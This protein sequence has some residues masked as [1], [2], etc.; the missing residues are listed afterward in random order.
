[1][2]FVEVSLDD[3]AIANRL[4]HQVLGR[5]L[6]ELSPQTRRLLMS[7]EAMVGEASAQQLGRSEVRF[8]RREVRAFTGWT[9]FQV[10]THLDKLVS[11]EYVLVH[12][13]SRGQSYLYELVYDGGGKDGQPFLPG[14]IDVER[15]RE[16]LGK[17]AGYDGDFEP[18][19]G[20]FEG[21][22]SP[23]RAPIEPGSSMAEAALSTT[24]GAVEP[25][26]N[27]LQAEI[28][29]LEPPLVIPSCR[30]PAGHNGRGVLPQAH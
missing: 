5:S 14:L 28:A 13:G 30:I 25:V 12:R 19:S 24:T 18:L 21:G 15:L 2:P 1:V 22:S 29:H 4:A 8:S 27:P 10:R 3:I 9:D 26:S 16:R 7:L 6:D 23:H 20:Y 17:L 11:L